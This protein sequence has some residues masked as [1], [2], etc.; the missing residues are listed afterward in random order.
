MDLGKTIRTKKRKIFIV[1][2]LVLTILIVIAVFTSCMGPMGGSFNSSIGETQDGIE[3]YE[4]ARG[5][6]SQEI[7]VTGSIDSENYVTYNM[8][9][10]GEV[11]SALEAG[12]TFKKGDLILE[13]D[14]KEKQDALFE[15]E[16]D[17]EISESSLRMAKL[18]YQ[19][20]LDSNH[21]AIQLADINKEKAEKTTASAYE[22]LENA[23]NSASI[24]Y[25]SAVSA[26]ESTGDLVSWNITKA[27]SALDEAERILEEAE[28]DPATTP[29]ELAQYEYNVKSAQENYEITK[30]QQQSSA[31]N[32]EVSLETT[33]N[34]NDAS[35][36]SAQ[37]SY[38]QSLLSQSSAYW[39]NLSSTQS[40]EA[41]IKQAAESLKQTEVK[42]ELAK[43]EYE[44]AKEDLKDYTI[45]APY[46]GIVVSTDFAVG[47]EANGGGSLSIIS[48]KF[49]IDC[50]VSESDIVKISSGQEAE[51]DF[52]AYTDIKFTGKVE[53]IIPIYTEDNGIIYYEVQVI[54]NNTEDVELLYG[55]S[56]NISIMDLKAEDILCIPLQA[57]YKEEGKSYVD[58][59][60]S[61]PADEGKDGMT[62]QKVEITTGVNDYY[63]IEVTS[64]LSEGDIIMTS[65]M[66]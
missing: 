49:V 60:V 25:D 55:F 50:M 21:I 22:S 15:I 62:I 44:N 19:S 29:E 63:N 47:G 42:L 24:S 36:D 18:S 1:L 26:L 17:I 32:A 13:I 57:V 65:R 6:I 46:D 16:K 5:N 27:K 61:D 53:K 11:L 40:A 23:V 30:T 31:Y 10:S 58:V 43:S 14:D 37:N 38:D 4:V 8:Q 20:A 9:V 59:L 12:D 3:T 45:D 66:Q 56:A 41:A 2:S 52:D 48:S 54:F 34:Q 51:V 33:K 64:G 35:I 39:S 28:A 7:S